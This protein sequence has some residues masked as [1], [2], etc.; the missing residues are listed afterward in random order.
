PPVRSAARAGGGDLSSARLHRLPA[1]GAAGPGGGPDVHRTDGPDLSAQHAI[2]GLQPAARTEGAR[3][4]S[5]FRARGP[6]WGA[7][8]DFRVPARIMI[9]RGGDSGIAVEHAR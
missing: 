3:T 1:P 7:G 9:R 8:Q 4:V 2:R 5:G 6:A